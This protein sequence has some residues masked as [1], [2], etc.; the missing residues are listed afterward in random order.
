M[1]TTGVPAV[2]VPAWQVSSPLQ[3]LPS[4]QL[5][6]SARSVL[7][8]RPALQE[9]SVQGLLSLHSDDAV[10]RVQPAMVSLRQPVA[11]SQESAVQGLLS[12]QTGGEPAVQVPAWQVSAPLQAL[13]SEQLVPLATGV[14]VQPLAGSQESVV[15]GLLSSQTGGFEPV[16]TP[17]WQVS[18]CVQAFPSLQVV[19]LDFGGSEHKPVAGLQTPAS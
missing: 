11:G 18:V 13:P 9:S 5:A 2:Q 8:Q 4:E 7:M 19:P 12:S 15:Q 3:R 1:Q 16:H 14:A 10:H 17:A 6:P